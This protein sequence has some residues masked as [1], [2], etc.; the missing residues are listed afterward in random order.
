LW[1]N[2]SSLVILVYFQ[3]IM[4][5]LPSKAIVSQVG[6][7]GNGQL[8]KDVSFYL[9]SCFSKVGSS[10]DDLKMKVDEGL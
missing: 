6:V 8:V 10:Q 5:S 9:G 1:Y 4:I 7:K 2:A 3:T